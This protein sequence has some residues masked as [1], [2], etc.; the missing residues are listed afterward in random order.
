[1]EEIIKHDDDTT[2]EELLHHDSSFSEVSSGNNDTLLH[3]AASWNRTSCLSVLLRFAP[4]LLDVVDDI[5]ETL[6]M[7]AVK[8]DK[9]DVAKM[10]LRAGADVRKM[11]NY[12]RTVFDVARN[13][14][15]MLEILEQHQQVSGIF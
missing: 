9:R 3:Y 6:L 13:N 4:H 15:E 5:N 8:Y 10:L 14:K 7:N 2:L 11:N 12:G 1:M